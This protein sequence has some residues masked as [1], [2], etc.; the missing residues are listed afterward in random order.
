M[1]AFKRHVRVYG[2]FKWLLSPALRRKFNIQC[3]LIPEAEGPCL[4]LANHNTDYDPLLMGLC[5]RK[6]TYYVA[7]E[8]I[9]RKGFLSKLLM[10][11]FAPIS[12]MKG[13]N[14]ANTVMEI[15]RRLRRGRNVCMFAEGNR[16]WDGRTGYILPATGKLAQASRATLVTYRFEGGYFTSPRWSYTLRRGSMRGYPVG[17]YPPAELAAMTPDEVNALIVRDLYEDAYARQAE[18]SIPVAFRGRRLAEGVEHALFI[19]PECGKL[20]TL[21]SLNNRIYCDCGLEVVYTPTGILEGGRFSTIPE[22]DDYQREK[23][24]EFAAALGDNPAF[25]DENIA[26]I[27][28]KEDHTNHITARGRLV[29]YADRLCVGSASIPLNDISEFSIHGRSIAVFSVGA[30]HYELKSAKTY[31]GRKYVELYNILKA[32]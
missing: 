20:G 24:A 5:V 8:H 25:S 31:C 4:I 23:L 18:K 19:C 28:I 7:S 2:F 10:R 6:Q 32:R 15:M 22:W 12:R 21:H 3:E 17:I 1:D 16:S 27:N 30:E 29:M 13:S 11:Y 9:F 26:L 14:A